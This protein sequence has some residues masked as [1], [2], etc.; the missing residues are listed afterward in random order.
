[1]FTLKLPTKMS[2]NSEK[3][4]FSATSSSHDEEISEEEDMD[5]KA[6]YS[7]ISCASW[8]PIPLGLADTGDNNQEDQAAFIS[9]HFLL[10][11]EF[12]HNYYSYR[13]SRFW[14]F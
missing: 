10:F 6:I 7:Q 3:S 1:M 13:L 12:C 9:V 4:S 2:R 14:K 8:G 5:V 11:L